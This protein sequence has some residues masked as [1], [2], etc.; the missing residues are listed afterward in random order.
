VRR[1][2]IRKNR[3]APYDPATPGQKTLANA[4][5]K[6]LVNALS[7]VN[8][9]CIGLEEFDVEMARSVCTIEEIKQWAAVARTA[10]S[11]FRML[12]R[13]LKRA[14][15]RDM[16]REYNVSTACGMPTGMQLWMSDAEIEGS[17]KEF[18][19]RE[20]KNAKATE[21]RRQAA[22]RK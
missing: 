17:D 20:R 2:G 11:A 6:K 13:K 4:Q 7:H 19:R 12:A 10:V 15:D 18:K 1:R 21:R 16:K 14:D 8:G 3:D 22:G 5:K 9:I